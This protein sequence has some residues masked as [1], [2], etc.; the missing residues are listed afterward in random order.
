MFY[1]RMIVSYWY[2]IARLIKRHQFEL[3]HPV[4]DKVVKMIFLRYN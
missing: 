4:V 1:M 2:P 3:N